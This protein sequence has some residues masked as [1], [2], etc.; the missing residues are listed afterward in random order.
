MIERRVLFIF[1]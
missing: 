1:A